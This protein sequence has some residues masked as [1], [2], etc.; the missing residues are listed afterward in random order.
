MA[1]STPDR[2]SEPPLAADETVQLIQAARQGDHAALERLFERC[3]PALRRWARGRLPLSARGM[4]DTADLVQDTVIA[5]LRALDRFEP[6]HQGALQAYL[7]Q[8]V[9]NRIRDLA[10]YH[11]RRPQ[12]VEMPAT[13]AAGDRSP[14]EL[15]IGAEN[16]ERYERSLARLSPGD[17]EAIIGRLEMQYSFDELA[18]LLNKPSA[19]AARMTVTRAIKRLAD[20]MHHG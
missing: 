20:E 6:R 13:L 10:R 1:P 8:A 3:I 14:L 2:P 4:L 5:P 17:R 7:R 18:L 12:Q 16:V 11:G 19:A 9:M 15:A